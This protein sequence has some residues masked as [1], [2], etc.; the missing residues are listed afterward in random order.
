M[1]RPRLL[2]EPQVVRVELAATL[3]RA[4]RLRELLRVAERA[5]A[6]RR[7]IR[8]KAPALAAGAGA[9]GPRA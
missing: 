7:F 1:A 3:R 9:P 8:E 4:D 5:E 2:P 6:D